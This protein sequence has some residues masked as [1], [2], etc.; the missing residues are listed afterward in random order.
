[1]K[2]LSNSSTLTRFNFTALKA[3]FQNI[4]S[5]GSFETRLNEQCEKMT[6]TSEVLY[7]QSRTSLQWGNHALKEQSLQAM[8]LQHIFSSIQNM[9]NLNRTEVS[10]LQQHMR[11]ARV[12]FDQM[13]VAHALGLLRNSRTEQLR[14]I[15]EYKKQIDDLKREISSLKTLYASMVDANGCNDPS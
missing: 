3:I 8:E 2:E 11:N 15:T 4:N 1:M 13:S 10:D 5:I 14:S 6:N 9:R 12:K 7:A